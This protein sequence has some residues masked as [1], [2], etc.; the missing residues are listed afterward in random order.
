M[1]NEKVKCEMWNVYHVE[2]FF[3]VKLSIFNF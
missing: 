3:T 1:E 2:I